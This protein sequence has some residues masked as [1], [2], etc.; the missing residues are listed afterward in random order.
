MEG[1]AGLLAGLAGLAGGGDM[2]GL[3]GPGCPIAQLDL[4]LGLQVPVTDVL[5]SNDASRVAYLAR[6]GPI[7]H[8]DTK[9]LL[10][11]VRLEF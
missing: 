6:H 10:Q 11:G 7:I 2:E 1:L 9:P 8:A 3:A 4:I 5:F